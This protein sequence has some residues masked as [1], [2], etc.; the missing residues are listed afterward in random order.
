[1]VFQKSKGRHDG[2]AVGEASEEE[3]DQGQEREN[4]SHQ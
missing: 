1:M 2:E 3:R 4:L